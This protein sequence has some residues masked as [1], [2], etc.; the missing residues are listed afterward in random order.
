MTKLTNHSSFLLI[1][2]N[3]LHCYSV[4]TIAINI[5]SNK[6]DHLKILK[7]GIGFLDSILK[8]HL[9]GLDKKRNPLFMDGPKCPIAG[10]AKL[11]IG[12]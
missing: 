4:R 6:I 8:N 10:V 11:K 7:C 12:G 1:F 9:E 5:E 2:D 3:G